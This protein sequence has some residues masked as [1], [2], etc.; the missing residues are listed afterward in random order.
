MCT[1][2]EIRFVCFNYGV[3]GQKMTKQPKL[4]ENL[5]TAIVNRHAL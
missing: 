5:A 4:N 3:N 2:K 1:F